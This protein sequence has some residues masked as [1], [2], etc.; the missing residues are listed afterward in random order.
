MESNIFFKKNAFVIG[1]TSGA[2]LE[3]ARLLCENGAFVT[4]TG[5]KLPKISDDE[6]IK[7]LKIEFNSDNFYST[8]QNELLPLLQNVDFLVYAAGPFVQKSLEQTQA[9]DWILMADL[10]FALP[11][12]CLS[13]A[14]QFMK[15]RNFGRIVIFG[16]TRTD[17]VHSYKT[18]AAYAGAKTALSVLVKSAAQEAAPFGIT[19]NAILPGFTHGAPQNTKNVS[20]IFL[21]QSVIYL[22]K[23]EVLNGVLMNVDR[24]WNP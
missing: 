7:F 23:N 24:G 4:A 3:T 16:G 17:S 9:D 13:S 6:K 1:G 15:K 18:N 8:F 12:M 21:A 10:N 14:L 5:R 11:G 19:C 22:M 20:E 2:G